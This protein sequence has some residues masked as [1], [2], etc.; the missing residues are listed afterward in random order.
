MCGIDG[1]DPAVL[2]LLREEGAVPNIDRLWREGSGGPLATATPAQSPVV[3]TT[4]ATGVNPGMHGVFDFIHRDPETLLP[5]LSICQEDPGRGAP[6][7]RVPRQAPAFWNVLTDAGVP[8]TALRWPV[9]FPPEVINGRMLSGL[10]TPSLRGTLGHYA[11]YTDSPS[12]LPDALPEHVIEVELRDGKYVADIQGPLVRHLT[13]VRASTLRLTVRPTTDGVSVDLDQQ[14]AV[15][16]EGQ[17][18]DWMPVHFSTGVLSKVQGMVKFRLM[19]RQGPLILYMTPIELDPRATAMPL[20]AP[21]GYGAELAAA[22]GAYHTLG[23]PEDTKALNEGALSDEAFLEQCREIHSERVAMFWHEFGRMR[24]GVLACVFDTSDRIQHMFWRQND[25]GP[26]LEIRSLSPAIHEHYVALDR[27][28]G[29]VM[30]ATDSETALLVFSD[31]GFTRFHTCFDLNAWLVDRGYMS[32][33]RAP[34]GTAD[35]GNALFYLVDWERTVAYACGFSGLYLNLRGREKH[36]I[37]GGNDADGLVQ[38]LQED[39]LSYKLDGLQTCPVLQAASRR[40][41]YSGPEAVSSPDIVVGTAPGYRMDWQATIGGVGPNVVRPNQQKWSGDHIVAPTCVPG[42]LCS[43][44]QLDLQDATVYDILPTVLSLL[45]IA[46]SAGLPG[47][48]L[49]RPG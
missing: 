10:G 28:L 24:E 43:N 5:Y 11:V 18:S 20:A 29:Q 22:I 31:H 8:V 36:G 46:P 23:M 30:A 44:L 48:S 47:R 1:L 6:R 35:Q 40:E 21:S 45:G 34:S 12:D 4:L 26:D 32:L 13:G 2:T 38:K 39:L 7:Y 49:V 41:L 42:T 25:L 19:R 3:W 33:K 27:F 15:L 14:N 9:T 37:V 17:W 16:R